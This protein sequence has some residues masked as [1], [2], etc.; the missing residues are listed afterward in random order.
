MIRYKLHVLLDAY[1]YY[2][3]PMEFDFGISMD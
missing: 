3:Y 2:A 1:V